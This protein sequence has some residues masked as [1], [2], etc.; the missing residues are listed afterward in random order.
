MTTPIIDSG[1]AIV[2]VGI[3]ETDRGKAGHSC[4]WCRLTIP[5]IDAALA[6]FWRSDDAEHLASI[7]ERTPSALQHRHLAEAQRLPRT[8]GE[9]KP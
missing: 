2:A 7:W 5:E 8:T 6:T 3:C 1:A 9:A 4:V